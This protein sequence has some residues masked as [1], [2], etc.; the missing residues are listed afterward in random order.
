MA[1]SDEWQDAAAVVRL[2]ARE[3]AKY[4]G[5]QVAAALG[6]IA[7]ELEDLVEAAPT[8]AALGQ[9]VYV[10]AQGATPAELAAE[11]TAYLRRGYRLHGSILLEGWATNTGYSAEQRRLYL[12]PMVG[13]EPSEG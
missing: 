6:K 12:Q 9:L 2:A 7:D 1:T 10:V 11:V 13:E 5:K 3:A 8:A 4:Q